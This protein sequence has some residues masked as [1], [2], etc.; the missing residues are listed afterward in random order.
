L[1]GAA[2]A[3]TG[4][5]IR[6]PGKAGKEI[7]LYK[8]ISAS[9]SALRPRGTTLKGWPAHGDVNCYV[10]RR[11]SWT[12]F[13]LVRQRAS[14]ARPARTT[15]L[16]LRPVRTRP[17]PAGP[18][19]RTR[20]GSPDSNRTPQGGVAAGALTSCWTRASR[21][22]ISPW[23]PLRGYAHET[24]VRRRV[25]NTPTPGAPGARHP[26]D[27][28]TGRAGGDWGGRPP[29]DHRS[30]P[31]GPGRPYLGP[32][33]VRRDRPSETQGGRLG[34][35]RPSEQD[36]PQVKP[37]HGTKPARRPRPRG[38]EEV[39]DG[40]GGRHRSPH[41]DPISGSKVIY[42]HHGRDGFAPE[43][44]SEPRFAP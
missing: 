28:T 13:K 43:E 15:Q 17:R 36:G 26:D 42:P 27:R 8:K 10:E 41:Q 30:H 6:F 9:V 16:R 5:R 11:R 39:P 25:H 7:S 18:P 21:R 3:C 34:R 4:P 32:A 20:E 22:R 1:A 2:R 38:K 14:A 24:G 23:S 40:Q 37:G 33:P 44:A 31:A 12:G 19:R 29:P 35:R